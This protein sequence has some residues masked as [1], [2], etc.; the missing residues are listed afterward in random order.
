M[1][2]LQEFTMEAKKHMSKKTKGGSE[3]LNT[4]LG[5]GSHASE[6]SNRT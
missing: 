1:N 6:Q 4:N 3:P 2:K 5:P